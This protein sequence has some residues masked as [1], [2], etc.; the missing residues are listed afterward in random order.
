MICLYTR[1]KLLAATYPFVFQLKRLKPMGMMIM[2][3]AMIMA[4]HGGG[5]DNCDSGND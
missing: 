3:V 2:V 4:I 1:M 5:Y